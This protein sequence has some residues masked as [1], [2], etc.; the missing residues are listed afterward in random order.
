[1]QRPEQDV[2]EDQIEWGADA[3]ISRGEP[4]GAADADQAGGPIKPGI[5]ARDA[6][7]L[8]VD[9]ARQHAL[10]QAPGG[11]NRQHAGS[12]AEIEDT[13]HCRATI[14]LKLTNRVQRDEAA[15]RRA[16][17]AGAEGQ[18][19]LDLDGDSV[20]RHAA[21]IMAAVHDKASRR[22]RL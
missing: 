2:G 20:R 18:R 16:V 7:G 6:H 11:G 1:M 21:A 3:K 8:C 17:M 13:R 19:R 12:G 9:I 14:T 4:I 5:V 22:N 10:A 15:A